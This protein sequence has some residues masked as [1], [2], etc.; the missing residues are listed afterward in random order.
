M[1]HVSGDPFSWR[2][3]GGQ[4]PVTSD[5]QFA[6]NIST[7]VTAMLTITAAVKDTLHFL[8]T[9]FVHQGKGMVMQN[10]YFSHH[11]IQGVGKVPALKAGY[12]ETLS[13]PRI[14]SNTLELQRTGR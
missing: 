12:L 6:H 14:Q 1:V 11:H 9:N 5:P 10:N 4:F 8:T 3:G 7:A 2:E 13:Q